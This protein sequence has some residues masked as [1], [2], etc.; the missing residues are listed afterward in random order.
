MCYVE[1][2]KILLMSFFIIFLTQSAVSSSSVENRNVASRKEC[3]EK[4]NELSI[5]YLTILQREHDLE[6]FFDEWLLQQNC[7]PILT[8]QDFSE[9]MKW[10][11]V[12]TELEKETF[13]V[14]PNVKP[15]SKNLRSVA[16]RYYQRVD[17][18]GRRYVNELRQLRKRQRELTRSCAE[19]LLRAS[20]EDRANF[21]QRAC[22][23]SHDLAMMAYPADHLH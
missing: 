7:R 4:I 8:G 22:G 23:L 10:L 1:Y 6:V 11:S 21:R 20:D 2:M 5:L 15:V 16:H 17:P 19:S 18:N 14:A 3:E 12:L 13:S 9:W